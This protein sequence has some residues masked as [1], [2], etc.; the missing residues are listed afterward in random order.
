[1]NCDHR[2]SPEYVYPPLHTLASL[3]YFT[4]ELV[5][6]RSVCFSVFPL[7][8]K[9]NAGKITFH[10]NGRRACLPCQM[11]QHVFPHNISSHIVRMFYMNDV[12]WAQ[13]KG[14]PTSHI[15]QNIC[16][17]YSSFQFL[18]PHHLHL[19]Q[20]VVCSI[21]TLRSITIHILW[22]K[23]LDSGLYSWLS[24]HGATFLISNSELL[25]ESSLFAFPS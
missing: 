14:Q 6:Q 25:M 2:F 16:H 24:V 9:R 5:P 22:S 3:L 4:N 15:I 11:G 18:L 13:V 12:R 1:M 23:V 21:E 19:L 7:A 20:T 8:S 17:A 10:S